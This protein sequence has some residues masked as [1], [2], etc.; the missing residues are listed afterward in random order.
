LY[1]IAGGFFGKK[2]P[3]SQRKALLDFSKKEEKRLGRYSH[4]LAFLCLER[5]S[6]ATYTT[7]LGRT[8]LHSSWGVFAF[9]LVKFIRM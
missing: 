3:P 1:G 2:E 6:S 7:E 5:L 8:I 4:T 9:F